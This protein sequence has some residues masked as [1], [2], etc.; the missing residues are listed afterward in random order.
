MRRQRRGNAVVLLDERP[1]RHF[2]RVRGQHELDPQRADRLVQP[3]RG[4]AARQQTAEGVLA[5]PALRRRQRIALIRPAPADAVMLLGDVGQ[6]EEV[7]ERARD[8]QR[9]VE[10]HVRELVGQDHEVGVMAG[11]PALGQRAHPFD[12]V[13]E[14]FPGLRSQRL[15][16]QLSEQPHIV[17]ERFVRIGGHRLNDIGEFA[18]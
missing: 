1:A 11:A 14:P 15:A 6:V 2:G 16:Q 9:V 5:R 17:A 3:L 13:E 4:D 18:Y 8:G 12:R 7:R 10:R